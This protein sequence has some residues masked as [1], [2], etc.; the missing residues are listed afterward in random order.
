MKQGEKLLKNLQEHVVGTVD[1]CADMVKAGVVKEG[2]WEFNFITIVC[3]RRVDERNIADDNVKSSFQR[4]MYTEGN[5]STLIG[6]LELSKAEIVH[7]I[8]NGD[9]T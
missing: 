4:M 2:E 7:N 9:E 1:I 5:P 3:G 8:L 6:V